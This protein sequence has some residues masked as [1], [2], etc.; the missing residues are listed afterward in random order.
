MDSLGQFEWND[1][2]SFVAWED[3]WNESKDHII[4]ELEKMNVNFLIN[5][6]DVVEDT[7][8]D[9]SD[10]WSHWFENTVDHLSSIL[11][12]NETKLHLVKVRHIE[13]FSLVLIFN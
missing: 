7:D 2:I 9:G 11:G 12:K 4:E 5:S 3:H 8:N 13:H 6:E 10:H 1:F